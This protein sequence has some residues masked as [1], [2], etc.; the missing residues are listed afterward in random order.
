MRGIFI[1]C[2]AC[3]A[4]GHAAAPPRSVMNST[5]AWRYIQ[6]MLGP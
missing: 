5:P 2:C 4:S 6:L 1:T 3:A